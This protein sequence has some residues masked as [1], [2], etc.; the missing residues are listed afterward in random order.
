MERESTWS[1]I[2]RATAGDPIAR[3]D[4]AVRYLPIV[5]TYL[6]ARWRGRPI[7]KELDDAVQDVFVDLLRE[8]GA[9]GR[10]ENR[11]FGFR[12]FLH[13]VTAY[14]ARRKET[15][16]R[17]RG[18]KA[19]GDTWMDT[20]PVDEPS[21]T[22]LFDREWA[23]A[24]MREAMSVLS[25]RADVKGAEAMRRIE[26]L[27]LR[28]HEGLPV[29]EI[30]RRWQIDADHLHHQLEQA[31]KEFQRA[32]CEVMGLQNAT[33]ARIATAWREFLQVFARGRQLVS[34]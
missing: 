12:G 13:G 1:L 16:L 34:S 11:G 26:L 33:E 30:A 31:K 20:L 17:R 5:R 32:W 21:L 7:L 29:R 25:E 4:F 8:G 18:R 23:V 2:E 10:A 6:L 15:E 27:R 28:F 3:S 22:A 14:V 19:A 24:L 9:L